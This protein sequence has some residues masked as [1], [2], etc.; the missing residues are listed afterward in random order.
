MA[1]LP[2]FACSQATPYKPASVL[3]SKAR[4]LPSNRCEPYYDSWLGAHSARHSYDCASPLFSFVR[5]IAVGRRVLSLASISDKLKV[6]ATR[7][8]RSTIND[9]TAA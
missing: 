9:E 1:L 3:E 2:S 4:R 5:A 8:Y 6:L 7:S